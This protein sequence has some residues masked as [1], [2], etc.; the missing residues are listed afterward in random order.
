M[1]CLKWKIF[2]SELS[3]GGSKQNVCHALPTV[4][5]LWPSDNDDGGGGDGDGGGENDEG[6]D[7]KGL[8]I[9]RQVGHTNA[10]PNLSQPTNQAFET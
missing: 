7:E 2:T 9:E 5:C 10:Q 3:A 6:G 4:G 1:K 8:W